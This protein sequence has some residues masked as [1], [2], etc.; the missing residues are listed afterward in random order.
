M[1]RPCA[2]VT[3][4]ASGLG[5]AMARALASQGQ[6]LL[7]VDRNQ[8]LLQAARTA[9]EA[10]GSQ[11]AAVA[12]DVSTLEGWARVQDAFQSLDLE[13]G[14]LVNAAGIAVA[15]S[16]SDIPTEDWRAAIEVNLLGPI[17]GCHAF[18]PVFQKQ[19]RGRIVNV[20]SRAAFTTPPQMGPYSTS[21][22]GLVAFTE[23]LASELQ[24][25]GISA[26]VVCSG[27]FRSGFAAG[28]RAYP[29]PLALLAARMIEASGRD[30][31]AVARF[32]LEAAGA[33]KL[34]A[35]PPGQDR[36]LWRL[37]RAAPGACR[38]LVAKKYYETLGKG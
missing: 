20:A 14:W 38:R 9:V 27:F 6:A 36:F 10:A 24:G 31:D 28:M 33:G 8:E 7:L 17:W 3:G 22:A 37:K 11:A 21:K 23:T 30:A 32:I 19:G 4:A 16:I 1:R 5:L 18:L 13:L 34:Y 26:T 29:P 15:G 35:V 12:A 25:T 2:I